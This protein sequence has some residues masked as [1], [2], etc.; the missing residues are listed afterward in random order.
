MWQFKHP[1][2]TTPIPSYVHYFFLSILDLVL[3]KRERK[4]K[5]GNEELTVQRYR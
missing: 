1:S 5:G 2:K 4:P 3:H